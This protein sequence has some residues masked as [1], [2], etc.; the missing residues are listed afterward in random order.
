MKW[1]K[2][3]LM[4]QWI[5]ISVLFYDNLPYAYWCLSRGDVD[6]TKLRTGVSITSDLSTQGINIHSI[7]AHFYVN[8]THII[9][10]N[11]TSWAETLLNNFTTINTSYEEP[12]N[13]RPC[14]TNVGLLANFAYIKSGTDPP[15]GIL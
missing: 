14:V 8:K 3:Q 2:F 1:Q 15:D 13:Y 4:L 9:C 12:R 5:P 10:L 11:S 7:E 6:E